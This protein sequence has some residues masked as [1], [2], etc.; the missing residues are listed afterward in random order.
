MMVVN[1][2]SCNVIC[3]YNKYMYSL[4]NILF[5]IFRIVY[6][7]MLVKKLLVEKKEILIYNF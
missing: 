3:I 4:N 6:W 7:C 2:D 1:I 5:W